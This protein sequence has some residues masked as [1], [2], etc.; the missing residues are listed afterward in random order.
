MDTL[1]DLT[2]RVAFVTGAGS[3][4][5]RAVSIGFAQHGA[6]VVCLDVNGDAVEETADLVR[7]E[8]RRAIAAVC[9]VTDV[10]QLEAVTDRAVSECQRIDALFNSVGV[11]K[12]ALVQDT[13]PEDWRRTIEV[14]LVGVFLVC[15]SVGKVM[16]SQKKGSIINVGSIN[17]LVA[18]QDGRNSAYVASKGGVA[19]LSRELAI[20]WAHLNIRVNTIAPIWTKTPMLAGVMQDEA[21]INRMIGK[22][23]LGRLGE[24][25]DMVGPAVFLASDAASLVTGVTLPVDGGFTAT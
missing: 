7:Q 16:M 24:P 18:S 10:E 5:G 6:D 15:K 21:K 4:I 11:S 23:P 17:S 13:V 3:G 25:E 9:D 2:G 1:F 22:I 8:D 19:A 12:P 14:N 20:E